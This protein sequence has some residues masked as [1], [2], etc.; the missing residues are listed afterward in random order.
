MS[1]AT[2]SRA[3]NNDKKVKKTTKE[4]VE[5]AAKKLNYKFNEAARSL[6]TNKSR[7][8]G[9]VAPELSNDFFY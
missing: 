5:K 7:L 3:L 8:I 4:K 6:K 9:I 2:V 1:T